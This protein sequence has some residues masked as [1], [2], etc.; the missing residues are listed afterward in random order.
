MR[1]LF[2]LLVAVVLIAVGAFFLRDIFVAQVF[3]PTESTT[4]E[5]EVNDGVGVQNPEVVVQNLSIPWELVF[6]PNGDMVVTE[7]SGTLLLIGETRDAIEISGVEHRGEGGLLGLALHPNFEQNNWIYLYLTTQ[8]DTGLTNRVERYVLRGAALSERT[9]IIEN[10]PGA[11]FHDG[12]RIAFGPDGL[13]YIATGDAG[14]VQSA[15]DTSSLAGK[16]LRIT[17]TGAIPSS[18]PFGNAV[19]SYGHRNVQGL[20]WDSTGILWATEHGPSGF[21]SGFDELNRIMSG[22]NYGWPDIIGDEVQEGMEAPQLHSGE[23]DVWA[24]SGATYINGHV[25]FAGLR[26]ESLYVA[27]VESGE[28]TEFRTFFR[29]EYGRLRTVVLGSDGMLYMLTNNTDG[30][31]APNKND[32]KI[33]RI[34]PRLLGI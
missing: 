17:D 16:I 28:A 26:G 1:T 24:P 5:G 10:I 30:R 3:A 33:I 4:P 23:T 20:A 29:E 27:T 6:L 2:I 8:T 32:D 22:I 21:E 13:L 19:Y 31:G 34:D 15:Q 11:R 7:R 12:G 18:N 9:V 14:S 25:L